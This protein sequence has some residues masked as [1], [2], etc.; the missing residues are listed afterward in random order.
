MSE[1][2]CRGCGEKMA[3]VDRRCPRCRR[4]EPLAY[5][6]IT[7]GFVLGNLLFGAFLAHIV[8]G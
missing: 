2:T 4:I 5:F 1:K 8:T 3:L 6:A 7:T